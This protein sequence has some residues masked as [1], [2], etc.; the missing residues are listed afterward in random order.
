MESKARLLGH[1]I[2]QI[3]V[4]FPL[5]LLGTSVVFD[6]IGLAM[7]SDV[8]SLVAFY[9]IG[10]GVLGGLGA[11]LFGFVDYLAIPGNTRAK[12]IGRLHGLSSFVLLVLF[13]CSWYLRMESSPA[14][15]FRPPMA[16]L[17][18][19]FGGAAFAALAGWLGGELVSRLGV[20]IDD[21]AHLDAPSS[22]VQP[23]VSAAP[24]D[25]SPTIAK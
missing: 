10:A 1:S 3:L 23:V 14:P 8:W 4:A 7:H 5:G 12:R 9:M 17:V 19:S 11:A 24:P 18:L 22:L 13:A 15:S 20:G 25:M 16:A 2:H 21:G 6:A